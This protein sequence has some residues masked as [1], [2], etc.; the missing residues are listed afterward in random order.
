MRLNF[1]HV[2]A[3]IV[4]CFGMVSSAHG[5]SGVAAPRNTYADITFVGSTAELPRED[6][7]IG[8]ML[9]RQEQK[10]MMVATV[11]SRNT[12]AG[13]ESGMRIVKPAFVVEEF[14]IKDGKVERKNTSNIDLLTAQNVPEGHQLILKVDFYRVKSSQASSLAASL[15]SMGAAYLRAGATPEAA[16][17][18]LSALDAIAA[19]LGGDKDVH[20]AIERGLDLSAANST[21]TIYFYDKGMIDTRVRSDEAVQAQLE[22]SIAT[23]DTITINFGQTFKN[24]PVSDLAKLKFGEFRA[25]D[26][27]ADRRT[28]CHELRRLLEHAYDRDTSTYLLAIAIN[29]IR[30]PQ[31]EISN[32]C[33]DE[34]LALQL[35][36]E[37][38]LSY[39][40]NCD[41]ELCQKTKQL[42]ILLEGGRSSVPMIEDLGCRRTTNFTAISKW[43][44]V[45]GPQIFGDLTSYTVDSCLMTDASTGFYQHRLSWDTKTK[46]LKAHA[47]QRIA[48]PS[49]DCR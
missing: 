16:N 35:K 24:Q 20:L 6:S 30:W 36:E 45:R 46:E 34:T 3:V 8:K 27:S 43:Q 40:A 1:R 17:I 49:V 2:A 42:M 39:I 10:L 15:R 4:L 32:P 18:A 9:R 44:N 33:L 29:D 11:L 26:S 13:V 48:N 14:S 23:R 25:V 21:M 28:K 41:K 12:V 47:C 19:I 38:N 37:K 22:F 5:Q 7:W 31:D